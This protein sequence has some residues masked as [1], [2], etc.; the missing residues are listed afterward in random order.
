MGTKL[1]IL[2]GTTGTYAVLV[3]ILNYLLI[4]TQNVRFKYTN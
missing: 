1:I 4:P 2:L 3:L